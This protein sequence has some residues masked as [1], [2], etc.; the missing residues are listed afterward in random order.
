MSLG[1]IKNFLLERKEKFNE[2]IT[3]WFRLLLEKEY[4]LN[5]WGDIVRLGFD[6][7]VPNM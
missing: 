1:E 5:W 4:L 2:D 7:G 3:P 6:K